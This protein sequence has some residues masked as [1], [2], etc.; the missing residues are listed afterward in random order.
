MN[1]EKY[2]LVT[3]NNKKEYFVANTLIFNNQVYG[4]LIN[5]N[6]DN[7][8][9]ITRQKNNKLVRVSDEKELQSIKNL[10]KENL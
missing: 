5:T 6:E 9:F 1:I 7:D 3:L 10:I 4:L 2:Q 8:Y